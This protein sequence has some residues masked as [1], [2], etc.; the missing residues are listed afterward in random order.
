MIL[1]DENKIFDGIY[2][3]EDFLNYLSNVMVKNDDDIIKLFSLVQKAW[4]LGE[5]YCHRSKN[6][7]N[8]WYF[9]TGGWSGNESIL[10]SL[11]HNIYIQAKCEVFKSGAVTIYSWGNGK[12]ILFNKIQELINYFE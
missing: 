7:K 12:Q 3:S 9:Y 6:V 4:V 2:P 10:A 8:A 5:D 11:K 1:Y